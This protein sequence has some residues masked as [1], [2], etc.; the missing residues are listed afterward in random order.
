MTNL[1]KIQNTSISKSSRKE[2]VT[3]KESVLL[4]LI[5]TL[6]LVLTLI[7]LKY[8]LV[9]NDSLVVYEYLEWNTNTRGLLNLY[10]PIG[11]LGGVS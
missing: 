10:R 8:I 9:V 7:Y 1:S 2:R 11:C 3:N 5:L 6:I 4:N